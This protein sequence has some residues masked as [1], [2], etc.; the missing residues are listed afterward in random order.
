MDLP[1]PEWAY[2]LV[3]STLFGG[4]IFLWKYFNAQIQGLIDRIDEAREENEALQDKIAKIEANYA[5]KF[6]KLYMDLLEREGQ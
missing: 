2:Q 4:V 3:V 5:A 1:V 6:E